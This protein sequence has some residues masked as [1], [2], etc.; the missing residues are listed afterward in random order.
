MAIACAGVAASFDGVAFGEVVDIKIVVGGSLPLARNSRWALDGGS[1][2][3][4]CLSASN[5]SLTT[6]GKKATLAIFGGGLTFSAKAICER[7][8]LSGKVNDIAR[9]AAS[10]KI[11]PE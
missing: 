8:E 10:F 11:V 6:Y 1:I 5:I 2:T 9:Y 3:L 4:S 7:V